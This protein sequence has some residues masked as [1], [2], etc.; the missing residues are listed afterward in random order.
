V[1][2]VCGANRNSGL[3]FLGVKAC[4]TQLWHSFFVRLHLLSSVGS[5]LTSIRG[6]VGGLVSCCR[7][8]SL[9]F[10]VS[11]ELGLNL[12]NSVAK[13]TLDFGDVSAVTEMTAL[14]EVLEIGAKFLEKITWGPGTH[15]K[16]N[17][18][19]YQADGL[20]DRRQRRSRCPQIA[21]E[22]AKRQRQVAC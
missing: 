18:A 20:F 22:V 1:I 8:A 3:C 10:R 19:R 12:C 4:L 9:S 17:L 14:I 5:S 13:S 7:G 16:S 2:I 11:G 6:I 15:R 21:S